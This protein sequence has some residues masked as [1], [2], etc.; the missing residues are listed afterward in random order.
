MCK[1]QMFAEWGPLLGLTVDE[2]DFAIDQAFKAVQ[3][4]EDEMERK[5]K[6]ILGEVMRE[7]RVALVM[8]GRPYHNDPGLNHSVL[9]EFQA[10]GYPFLSMRSLP[11]DKPTLDTLFPEDLA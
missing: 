11:R 7:N 2:N 4:F 6:E 5:G 8:L 1:Q 9:E 10:L 3:A